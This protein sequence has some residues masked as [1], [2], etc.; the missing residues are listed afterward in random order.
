MF[1]V[2]LFCAATISYV[3]GSETDTRVAE[4]AVL[5]AFGTMASVTGAYVFG[6]VWQDVSAMRSRDDRSDYYHSET[7]QH[8]KQTEVGDGPL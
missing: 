7:T 2:T 8:V 1:C 4:T 3:L 5:M 6:A